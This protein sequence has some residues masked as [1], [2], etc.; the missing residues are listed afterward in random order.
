MTIVDIEQKAYEEL[1]W[2]ATR[3]F[4]VQPNSF[5]N[6]SLY[7][8]N[9]KNVDAVPDIVNIRSNPKILLTSV[10]VLSNDT[11]IQQSQTIKFSQKCT[12]TTTTSTTTG[13]KIGT[14][15]KST[16]KGKIK[17]G[18]LI[19][20]EIEQSVEVSLT[21]EYNHSTTK[22]T[23][24]THEE[25]WEY[26]QPVLVPARSK[27]IATFYIMGGPVT[28]PMTLSANISGTGVSPKGSPYHLS[29][30][31]FKEQNFSNNSSLSARASVLYNPNWS[32]YSP[33]FTGVGE[34]YS[35]NVEGASVSA[36]TVGLY[37]YVE[38]K[39]YPLSADTVD[40]DAVP[41]REYYSTPILRNGTPALI[42]TDSFN[43]YSRFASVDHNAHSM[44]KEE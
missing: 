16:T 37:S 12:E 22:T 17:V 43:P 39:E 14:S 25:L 23:T 7:S 10:Q 26:T 44:S 9:I 3:K 13:Y 34:N 8:W 41:M 30:I 42:P 19:A 36:N 38:F 35:L 24:S 33:V 32:G 2:Y 31:Y 6:P 5:K 27:V 4:K 1:K 40:I 11:S 20:G 15:I 28:I 29:K 18:F 21:G